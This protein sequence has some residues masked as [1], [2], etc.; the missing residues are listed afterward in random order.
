MTKSQGGGVQRREAGTDV[1]WRNGASV[2]AG[3]AS[4]GRPGRRDSEGK[5]GNDDTKE[6]LRSRR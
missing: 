2:R 3:T 5:Q 1:S 6:R 4:I